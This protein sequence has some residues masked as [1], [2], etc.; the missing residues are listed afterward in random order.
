MSTLLDEIIAAR[1]A[2][3]V[4]Y[5]T[6]L[7]QIGAVA[8]MVQQG[9]EKETPTQLDS[10]GK[11]ALYNNLKETAA[12]IADEKGLYTTSEDSALELS[13]AIDAAIKL[14]RPDGWRGVQAREQ[15][16]KKAI[17]DIVQD[18]DEVERLFKIIAAPRNGY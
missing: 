5:E 12:K 10:P 17:Y 16:I 1:K 11:L 9:R 8:T 18:V 6:Y 4:E 13:L 2:K 7:Q 14:N 3:A 15:V